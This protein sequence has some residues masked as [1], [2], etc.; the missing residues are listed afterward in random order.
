M[1]VEATWF[2]FWGQEII[3]SIETT[4]EFLLW[5]SGLR[6]QL[7]CLVSLWSYGFDPPPSTTG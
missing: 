1:E 5:L 3:S 4:T 7:Q 6:I 2:Q